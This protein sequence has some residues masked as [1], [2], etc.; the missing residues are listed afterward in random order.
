MIS[1]PVVFA[2]AWHDLANTS[3]ADHEPLFWFHW[4]LGICRWRMGSL[5]PIPAKDFGMISCWKREK[6]N[7]NPFQFSI[8][9]RQ[10]SYNSCRPFLSQFFH[11]VSLISDIF[12][13][14]FSLFNFHSKLCSTAAEAWAERNMKI[15]NKYNVWFNKVLPDFCGFLGSHTFF[16]Y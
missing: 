14:F 15:V 13:I 11:E 2:P 9:W 3:R 10:K 5:P 6:K 8:V 12:T 7:N 16:I 1:V 4:S